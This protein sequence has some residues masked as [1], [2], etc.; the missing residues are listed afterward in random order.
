MTGNIDVKT[1]ASQI[2][3]M[4]FL[5]LLATFAKGIIMTACILVGN[6]IGEDDVPMA[7]RFYKHI[8]FFAFC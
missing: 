5:N 8:Y 3:Y 7:K 6:K 4:Q 1:L 2:I